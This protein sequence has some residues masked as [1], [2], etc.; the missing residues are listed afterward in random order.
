MRHFLQLFAEKFIQTTKHGSFL[1]E[2]S[3]FGQI[4]DFHAF[5]LSKARFATF[6][7]EVHPND[8]T[9]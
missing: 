1:E 2:V 5:S 3:T 8:E 4:H 9:W 6:C 7:R